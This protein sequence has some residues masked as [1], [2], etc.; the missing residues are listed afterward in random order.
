MREIFREVASLVIY[1]P[2]LDKILVQDR[3]SISKYGEE[4]TFFGGGLDEGETP[5]QAA[6]RE[7][8]EEL[9]REFSEYIYISIHLFMICMARIILDI[10]SLSTPHKNISL[11]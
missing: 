4:V 8:L 10:F 6:Q 2:I 3:T 9:W 11:I 7:S 5:L 1:N